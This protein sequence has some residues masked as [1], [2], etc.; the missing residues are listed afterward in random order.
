MEALSGSISGITSSTDSL[1]TSAQAMLRETH[2][3]SEIV[4]TIAT[5]SEQTAAA[6]EELSATA[7]EVANTAHR[8]SSEVENQG[9]AINAIETT[10]TDLATMALQL[11][12][13]S[14]H[15]TVEATKLSVEEHYS[16]AA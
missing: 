12:A 8:V 3:L 15:F 16:K 11:R 10:S 4:E 5:G 13:L 9:H 7:A 1:A 2:R 6:A 14:D